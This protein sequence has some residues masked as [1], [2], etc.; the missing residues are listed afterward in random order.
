MTMRKRTFLSIFALLI[1]YMLAHGQFTDSTL[2]DFVGGAI[3]TAGQSTDGSLKL[4]GNYS[5]HGDQY[6]MDMKVDGE[7]KIAVDG[8]CTV[9]FLGSAYSKLNMKGISQSGGVNLGEQSTQ[10]STDLAETFDFVYEGGTDTLIFTTTAGTGNDLYLPQIEVVPEQPGAKNNLTSAVKNIIYYFDFRDGSIIPNDVSFNGNFVLD[11]GLISIDPGSSNAYKFNDATHGAAFKTGNKITLQ[12]AGNSYIKLGGSIYSTGTISASSA[13][14]D[15]DVAS[16]S[17]TTSGNYGNDGSTVD[18]LYV[19]SAGEV[20][21]D[22]TSTVYLPIL[23][24]VPFPYDTTFNSYVQKS[25]DISFNGDTIHLT[26]GA[27]AS[28]NAT[29]TVNAGTVISATTEIASIFIDLGGNA[30]STSHRKFNG[31]ISSVTIS[32][33][34]LLVAYADSSST[35]YGYKIIVA[36]NS[37]TVTAEAGKTYTYDLTNGSEMPQN[38]TIKYST[39]I[40]NDGIVTMNSNAGDPFWYHDASHGGV[41]YNDNSMDFIVA[42]NATI[43]LTTCTYSAA[44]SLMV[45]TNANGD[46]LGA[47]AADNNG[48]ADAFASSFTYTGGAGV[49]TGTLVASGAVYLHALTIENAAAIQPSNGKI[50]VWD[51]GAEQLDTAVYNNRL[52]VDTINSWYDPSITAGSSGNVF[53]SFTA[54]VLSWVGGS[55]DRLRTTNTEI[56]RY[57]E[58]ISG[59]TGYTGRVYVNASAATGRYLSLSLTEDDEVTIAALSQNGSG[60]LNFVYVPD[61]NSQT[62]AKSLGTDVAE[63]NFV[64]KQAGTYHIYDDLDKPS[65]Y[66]IYRKDATY[67]TLTGN[68]DVSAAPG[69]PGDYAIVFTNEAGKAW[70]ST[71]SV[72]GYSVT[73]PAGYSYSL[74]L[75]NANGYIISNGNSLDVTESTVNHDVVVQQ[76]ELYTVSGSITGLGS[77]IGKLSLTYTADTSAHKIYQPEPVIDANACHLFGSTGTQL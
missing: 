15:F 61:P 74:S 31:N 16:Q 51:F 67:L 57:D 14:G 68:V 41:F 49:I 34:T 29:V 3:V 73:L 38:T 39:F 28:D 72:G 36:D 43:T 54:G 42:G 60:R 32:G 50:D 27:T 47:I 59:V 76:V 7:I 58:N 26:S 75:E 52:S 77:E 71:M 46:S 70:T 48:G 56:T 44:N 10:V 63:F 20:Q 11:S 40:T 21:L 64:A 45:F 6:G 17:A 13:T 8:S 53:P 23:Y 62:D 9:R 35:P 65:Y 30:L 55:N 18:F 2:Y 19:G 24:V 25:G 22:F 4:S 5:D 37:T 66:R 33:D 12:V 1:S 69:I